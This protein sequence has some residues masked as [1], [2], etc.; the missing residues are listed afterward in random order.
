[1]T[2]EHLQLGP[3]L[4]AR[5]GRVLLTWLT[6]VGAVL[7]VCLALPPRYE[8]AAAVVAEMAGSD[9]ISGNTVF[10]P[11]ATMSTYM[12]T[13]ANIVRS[14]RVALGALRSLGLQKQAAWRDRWREATEGRGDFEAWL[15]GE[16]LRDLVVKPAYDSNVLNI[17][18]TSPDPKLSA[19]VVN[20]FVRS[21]IDLTLQ[22]QVGPAR[23]F[24]D[25]FE[26][27]AKLLRDALEQAKARLSAY[28]K[29]HGVI[30]A[31][32]RDVE[33]DRLAELTK[34]LVVLQ[35][36][37]TD[38][39]NRRRQAS[40]APS[41]M[42]DLRSDP[43]VL[44]LTTELARQQARL[45][46]LR[47]GLGEQHP[48]VAEARQ[49]ASALRE[50]IDASMQR[51]A[52]SME[53]PSRVI[54]ARLAEVQSAIARQQAI[55]LQRKSQR[56]AASALLR[57]VDSAQKAYDAVLQRA[58]Q[59]ALESANTTQT[60]ISVIRAATPAA[61]PVSLLKLS[62]AAAALLGFFLGIANAL[63]AEYR[64]RR[65]RSVEDITRLLRQPLLL[66]LPD[67]AS[68]RG[69][70]LRRTAETERRLVSMQHRLPAPR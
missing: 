66:A 18:F 8:A 29:E 62:L 19:D 49:A 48:A 14:E 38:A 10:K 15:A 1:M 70:G 17:S 7:A 34:Q 3:A 65:L 68:R 12:A 27:R 53:A 67:G 64:D 22:M 59:T 33:V 47:S 43:E 2:L 31:D 55:V 16:L 37:A 58:S 63:F 24:N 26:N 40:A 50:R 52:A 60:N 46:D 13:Q 5:W 21:Y 69:R 39:A 51:A 25:F 20:A 56:D 11:A 35:D 4:R 42:R 30:V 61:G 9:P 32:G 57:D 44:A 28:E 36:E 54:H 45:S 6:L 41:R 23:K